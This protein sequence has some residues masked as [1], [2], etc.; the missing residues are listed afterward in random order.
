MAERKGFEPLPGLKRRLP[1]FECG[2]FD[3]LGTSPCM[4]LGNHNCPEIALNF[5]V[6]RRKMKEKLKK[7]NQKNAGKP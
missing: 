2:P 6:K 1:H 5:G 4:K 7:P 3:H